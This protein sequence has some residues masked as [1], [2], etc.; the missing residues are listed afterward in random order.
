MHSLSHF[1]CKID[2]RVPKLIQLQFIFS[3]EATLDLYSNWSGSECPWSVVNRRTK[4]LVQAKVFF[5][6]RPL[7]LAGKT[8]EFQNLF[9]YSLI[10]HETDLLFRYLS[11]HLSWHCLLISG[12][13]PGLV[14]CNHKIVLHWYGNQNK[15]NLV[16]MG[17]RQKSTNNFMSNM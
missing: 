14:C 13:I 2:S 11:H 17:N 16:I 7:A 8:L 6:I 3:K 10:F 12:F 9:S 5:T 15:I 1:Y 4:Y